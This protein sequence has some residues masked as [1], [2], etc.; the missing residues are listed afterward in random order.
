[1]NTFMVGYHPASF[2]RDN[3]QEPQTDE[4]GVTLSGEKTFFIKG[5]IMAGQ[6][7]LSANAQNLMDFKWLTREELS[8][9]L[10]T[11]YYAHVK[12]SLAER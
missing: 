8:E 5:R 11:E 7:D 12:N 4:N 9:H 1:M 6:A 10:P 2:H 3:W